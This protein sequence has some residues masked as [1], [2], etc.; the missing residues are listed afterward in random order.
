MGGLYG[1]RR[2]GA[3]VPGLTGTVLGAGGGYLPMQKRLKTEE[4]IS[5]EATLPVMVPRW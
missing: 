4:R 1:F 5:S 3:C 2:R